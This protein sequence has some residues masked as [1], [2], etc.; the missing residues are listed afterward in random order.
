MK[1]ILVKNSDRAQKDD[2]FQGQK[3]QANEAEDCEIGEVW[4]GYLKN[5]AYNS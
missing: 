4:S 1:D 5:P 2:P 3:G